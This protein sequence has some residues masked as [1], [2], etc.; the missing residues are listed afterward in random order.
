MAFKDDILAD[1]ESILLE[2]GAIFS[3]KSSVDTVDGLGKVT[4]VTETTFQIF[5]WI[6]D[7]TKK[8]RKL[9]GSGIAVPGSRIVYFKDKYT[10][11]S[12][13]VDTDKVVK[14]GQVFVDRNS[15]GWRLVKILK[16]PF[17]SDQEIYKKGIVKSI[18]LQ[19]S[20]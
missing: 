17:F 3:M 18:G 14:E 9:H 11:T 15:Y 20:A 8:D 7:I 16:E 5:A 1:F 19:G 13:G 2:Q 4:A 6:T 10:T 12:A